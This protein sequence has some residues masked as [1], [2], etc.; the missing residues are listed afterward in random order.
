MRAAK[1]EL[2][3]LVD[4]LPAR[5]TRV[6]K[7]FLEFLLA[8]SRARGTPDNRQLYTP[9]E[10]SAV[11][12]LSPR[13]LRY[14]IRKDVIPARKQRGR[15]LINP[16]TLRQLQTRGARRFLSHPLAKDELTEEEKAASEEAWEEHLAGRT[17]T[18]EEVMRIF[19]YEPK[20]TPGQ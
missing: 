20:G 13:R 15:W 12:G 4:S 10:A 2:H 17:K 16:E 9:E 19:G 5:E 18:L 3:R 14:L 11:L 6:F 1:R 7:R 8:R